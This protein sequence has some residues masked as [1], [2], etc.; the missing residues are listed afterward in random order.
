MQATLHQRPHACVFHDRKEKESSGTQESYAL[1][2][3]ATQQT[4]V[5]R[6]P[7]LT[8]QGKEKEAAKSATYLWQDHHFRGRERLL[9]PLQAGLTLHAAPCPHHHHH[10]IGLGWMLS[11]LSLMCPLHMGFCSGMCRRPN[12]ACQSSSLDTQPQAAALPS[13]VFQHKPSAA[14]SCRVFGDWG[15]RI[16]TCRP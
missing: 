10:A 15:R 13:N 1:P 4:L 8:R 7:L 6:L 5:L 14:M 2:F 9:P 3:R 16:L 11:V 12:L